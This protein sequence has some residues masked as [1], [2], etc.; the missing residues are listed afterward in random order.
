MLFLKFKARLSASRTE[1]FNT[2]GFELHT[3]I[4]YESKISRHYFG[5]S[6]MEIAPLFLNCSTM[7]QPGGASLAVQAP[8]CS[9]SQMSRVGY[10]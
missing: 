9:S 4:S 6:A 2:F 1:N 3:S 8:H 5:L 7:T 10:T